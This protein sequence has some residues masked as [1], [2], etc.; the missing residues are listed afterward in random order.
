MDKIAPDRFDP[1]GE[2]ICLL[3]VLVIMYWPRS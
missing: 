2:A 1:I 3:G